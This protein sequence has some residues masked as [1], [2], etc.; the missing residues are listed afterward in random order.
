MTIFLFRF[1]VGHPKFEMD[2]FVI[3]LYS[4][5]NSRRER[6]VCPP[7]PPRL[8]WK[9]IYH[10]LTWKLKQTKIYS[11]RIPILRDVYWCR[12]MAVMKVNDSGAV[13]KMNVCRCSWKDN[14]SNPSVYSE[15]HALPV[16][17]GLLSFPMQQQ[18]CCRIFPA[19]QPSTILENLLVIIQICLVILNPIR[20]HRGKLL[21]HLDPNN[22]YIVYS[23]ASAC[24][25]HCIGKDG[26]SILEAHACSS[27]N[28]LLIGFDIF[29]HTTADP[30]R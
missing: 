28:M 1:R 11:C 6:S 21:F 13:F 26:K 24:I 12:R 8:R 4:I 27:L 23:S 30:H 3:S 19:T 17:R 15:L 2:K 25:S 22:E 18:R 16:R 14:K 9:Y 5:P 20:F 10:M 7:P 29:F